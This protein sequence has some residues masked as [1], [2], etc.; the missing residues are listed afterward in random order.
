MPFLEEVEVGAGANEFETRRR[1]G[2]GGVRKKA[3]LPEAITSSN[4]YVTCLHQIEEQDQLK[5]E[6][7][8]QLE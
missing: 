6:Q 5:E 2:L 8:Q 7:R 1:L 3:D 4:I